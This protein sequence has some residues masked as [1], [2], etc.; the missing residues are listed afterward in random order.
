M[1]PNWAWT[2]IVYR[3]QQ[4][5]FDRRGIVRNPRGKQLIR[6]HSNGSEWM[7]MAGNGWE[8]LRMDGNGREWMGMAGN[9]WEWPGMDGNGCEWMGMAG[10]GRECPIS[11]FPLEEIS[12]TNIV[13]HRKKRKKNIQLHF[14]IPFDREK[15]GL[16]FD[17]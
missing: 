9:G 6:S 8:W 15:K 10:N 16:S 4:V 13:T 7:G 3:T 12:T 11:F 17:V 2:E 1:S 14:Y 5:E